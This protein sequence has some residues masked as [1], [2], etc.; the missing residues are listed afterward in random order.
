MALDKRVT[1]TVCVQSL[2]VLFRDFFNATPRGNISL[3]DEVLRENC[4]GALSAA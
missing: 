4:R 1:C 2:D 3:E